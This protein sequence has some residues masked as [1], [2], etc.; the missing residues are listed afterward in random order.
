MVVTDLD[1]TLFR[2]DKTISQYTVDTLQKVRNS[3]IKIIFATARGGTAKLLV[4]FEMF[5]GF[6]LLNGA[7]A[8]AENQLI[9]DR[10]IPAEIYIPF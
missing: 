2:T 1:G 7:K 4:P 8:Y 3:G 5:D 9:Y 10:E 6:V